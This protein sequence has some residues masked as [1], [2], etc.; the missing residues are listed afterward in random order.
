[1]K[2]SSSAF[3]AKAPTLICLE[4]AGHREAIDVPIA[5]VQ[6][7]RARLLSTIGAVTQ[8]DLDWLTL[9]LIAD[10]PASAPA[11][12]HHHL[13]H[14]ALLTQRKLGHRHEVALELTAVRLSRD[15][16]RARLGRDS[17]HKQTSYGAAWSPV[18]EPAL[19]TMI[20]PLVGAS[21]GDGRDAAMEPLLTFASPQHKGA[22]GGAETPAASDFRRDLSGSARGPR[23]FNSA[24]DSKL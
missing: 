5:I 18:P 9:H 12:A 22:H 16:G 3:G 2:Q 23:P 1:M 6:K 21:D 15:K 7:G 24:I 10:L 17:P 11:S 13:L 4:M 8:S 19:E 14:S 20:D